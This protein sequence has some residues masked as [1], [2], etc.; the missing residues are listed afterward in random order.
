M[1]VLKSM[2]SRH[3]MMTLMTTSFS[4]LSCPVPPPFVF[5]VLLYLQHLSVFE[6]CLFEVLPYNKIANIEGGNIV[7][8]TQLFLFF[9]LLIWIGSH[10]SPSYH[11][12]GLFST[13]NLSHAHLMLF[14]L[15]SLKKPLI[16]WVLAS[17]PLWRAFCT[18][19]QFH[20]VKDMP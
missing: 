20:L 13:W 8:P 10:P 18:R 7:G 16:L 17:F 12:E 14:L 9:A 2:N 15:I 4:V 6:T 11:S 19:S 1:H 3:C 5:E